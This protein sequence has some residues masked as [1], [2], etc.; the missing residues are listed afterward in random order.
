MKTKTGKIAKLSGVIIDRI[1]AGEVVDSP[2]S[3]VKELTENSIDAGADKIVIETSGGGLERIVIDDNGS[4]I[5]PQDLPLSVERHATSKVKDIEDIQNVTSYGFR[6]EALAAVSSVSHMQIRAGNPENPAG[7]SSVLVSRGGNVLSVEQDMPRKGT[8]I[9][10][11][12]LFYATPARKKF[13]K[14]ERTENKKIGIEL[15]KLGL[16]NPGVTIEYVRDSKTVYRWPATLSITE[17]ISQIFSGSFSAGLLTVPVEEYGSLKLHGLISDHDSFRASRDRQFG[18]VNGRPV[19]IKNLSFFVKKAYGELCPSA[20]HPAW[21]LFLEA[22]LSRVDVNV[23]PA[24]KEV[25]LLDEASLFQLV[26]YALKPVLF[27]DEPLPFSEGGFLSAGTKPASH[28]AQTVTGKQDRHDTGHLAFGKNVTGVSQ[29]HELSETVREQPVSDYS[30]VI[31]EKSG[32][33]AQ[34]APP[35]SRFLPLRHFGVVFGTYILAEAEDG[36]YIIDQHTAHERVNYE[37]KRKELEQ[38][39]NQTQILLHPVILDFTVDETEEIIQNTQSLADSG[40]IVEQISPQSVALREVP[41][42]ID[43][44]SEKELLMHI[45]QRLTDGE[46]DVRVYDEYAAMKACKAS[47]KRNDM[48]S[49]S[50]ISQIL[51]ELSECEDPSR[52]PHGRPTMVKLTMEQL[53]RI[54]HRV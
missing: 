21:F 33:P 7:P 32:N 31:E 45:I 14:S 27:P 42:Y 25:R 46:K 53:D 20:S 36:L 52:C 40:F 12:E 29:I 48:V 22:D 16:A 24:K 18:F 8:A 54:F 44:G 41:E 37:R 50:V 30:A 51:H 35:K 5:S 4:G 1:A 15:M 38:R 17:R 2:A 47:I 19:D 43:P 49:G 11:E 10:V 3:V 28:M 26:Q 13:L 6:G 34:A 39:K 9:I 23:H